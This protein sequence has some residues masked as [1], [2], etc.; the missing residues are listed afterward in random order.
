MPTQLRTPIAAELFDVA[1]QVLESYAYAEALPWQGS[2]PGLSLSC[3]AVLPGGRSW[4]AL[5]STP[6]LARALADAST[7]GDGEGLEQDSLSEL[8]NI[9]TSHLSER[10]GGNSHGA[11]TRFLPEAGL[12][13]AERLLDQCLD[14][15]GEA[16]EISY[17]TAA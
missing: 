12:P 14:I 13:Q 17:W 5:R 4:V 8:C 1:C 2:T 3:H 11:W 10:L 7:G 9:L 16:L 15:D 6:G